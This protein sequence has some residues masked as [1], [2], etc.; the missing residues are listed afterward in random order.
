VYEQRG[1][2]TILRS[3]TAPVVLFGLAILVIGGATTTLVVASD[4]PSA[5][6]L[7]VALGAA[8]LL[9]VILVMVF[10]LTW[11][12]PQNLIYSESGYLEESAMAWGAAE[13]P[14]ARDILD[15]RRVQPGIRQQP[16]EDDSG[17]QRP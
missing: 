14:V 17:G 10:L 15:R 6:K 3:I 2:G 1:W 5:G 8:V 11:F 13:N 7:L 16:P 12:K 9:L 4:L